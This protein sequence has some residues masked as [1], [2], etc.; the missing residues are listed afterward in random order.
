VL[1]QYPLDGLK[2]DGS[3]VQGIT[4]NSDD[5]EIVSAV[6]AMAHNLR[7]R[8]VAEGT[9]TRQQLELLGARG[10][11]EAQGYIVSEPLPADEAT[12][13]LEKGTAAARVARA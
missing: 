7:L 12:R 2:I 11:D 13:F 9:E 3:F 6:I 4:S 10:C 5:L 8:V 1:K